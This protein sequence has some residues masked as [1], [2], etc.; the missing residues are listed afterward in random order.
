M[1]ILLNKEDIDELHDCIEKNID[2]TM[3]IINNHVH[4]DELI[5]VLEEKFRE[6]LYYLDKAYNPELVELKRQ[7]R[8][9]YQKWLGLKDKD[10]S[11]A[12]VVYLEYMKLKFKILEMEIPF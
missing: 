6:I 12:N 10:K 5:S 9:Y 4:N 11:T 8:L 3:I 7:S 1:K 2:L